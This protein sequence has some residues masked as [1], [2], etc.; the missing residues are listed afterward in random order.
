MKKQISNAALK[1]IVT[2]QKSQ[3]FG[4]W[5][6]NFSIAQAKADGLN[7]KQVV[8]AHQAFCNYYGVATTKSE[9]VEVVYAAIAQAE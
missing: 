7:E 4:N 8:A 1:R 6:L 2:A 5:S 3:G 9:M